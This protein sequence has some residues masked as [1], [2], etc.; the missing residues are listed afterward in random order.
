[1]DFRNVENSDYE[2][3]SS[4][5]TE[6]EYEWDENEEIISH[7]LTQ[8][9]VP[10]KNESKTS[11]N[12]RIKCKKIRLIKDVSELPQNL[13]GDKTLHK[14]WF[15]RYEIFHKYDDGIQLDTGMCISY[16]SEIRKMVI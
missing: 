16:N 11:F 1:M 3:S 9:D 4:N 14:Y 12:N 8:L 7:K 5:S 10:E 6:D 2:S 15:N 13:R